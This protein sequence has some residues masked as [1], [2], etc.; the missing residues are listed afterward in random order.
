MLQFC[1]QA[2]SP[3]EPQTAKQISDRGVSSP[4]TDTFSFNISD[5]RALIINLCFL[6]RQEPWHK[7]SHWSES[8]SD[9]SAMENCCV[10]TFC[11]WLANA[12]F[13]KR[14]AEKQGC[15]GWKG[16]HK[17]YK[18]ASAQINE[19]LRVSSGCTG[20]CAVAF[21][22]SPRTTFIQMNNA[23]LSAFNPKS[24]IESSSSS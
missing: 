6:M 22:V 13:S 20:L 15:L 14:K 8:S 24:W 2:L 9:Q 10:H 11:G 18:P 4:A 3:L 7:V 1:S 12:L 5:L 19:N 23:H 21:C 17:L 16:P